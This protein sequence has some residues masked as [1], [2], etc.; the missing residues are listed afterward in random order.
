M[1]I[2]FDSLESREIDLA[3]SSAHPETSKILSELDRKKLARKI[4][5]PTNDGEVRARLRQLDQPV[6]LFGE[7]PADRRDRLRE[8]LA[9]IR[10][11]QQAGDANDR[12]Q[13]SRASDDDESAS[14][15]DDDDA[16]AKDDEDEEFYTEGTAHLKKARRDIADYSLPRSVCLSLLKE[17]GNSRSRR[18]LFVLAKGAQAYRA[19]AHRFGR[20]ARAV[21]G[22]PQGRLLEPR[23]VHEPRFPDR[24]HARPL[25]RPVQSRLEI[26]LDGELDR[27]GET[28]ERAELQRGPN[29]QE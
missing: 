29:S 5:L 9:R 16:D 18:P 27:H 1:D 3:T 17:N 23:V 13:D 4:A 25:G 21:D 2:D 28:V 24:R 7:G 19:T 26:A 20:S 14:D 15:G 22:R 11:E 12:D 8:Y 6:T 10:M